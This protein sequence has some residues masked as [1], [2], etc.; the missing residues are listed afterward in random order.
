MQRRKFITESCAACMGLMAAGFT[1]SSCGT[2]LPIIKTQKETGD[3]LRIAVTGFTDKTN[4]LLV[5][6]SSLSNDILLIKNNDR[7]S[8]L[9]M[10]CTHE[11]VGLTATSQKI[12]CPSHGSEFDLEGNVVKEPALRNLKKFRTELN[13]NDIIIHLT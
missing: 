8:A 2:A 9:Y 6:N 5:R 4:M 10:R 7:Y 12:F 13:N 3:I 1:L 11:G